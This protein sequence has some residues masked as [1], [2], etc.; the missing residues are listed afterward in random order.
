MISSVKDVIVK[1]ITEKV[2]GKEQLIFYYSEKGDSSLTGIENRLIKKQAYDLVNSNV[3]EIRKY[4]FRPAVSERG[5]LY[6]YLG[7]TL[8][9]PIHS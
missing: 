2:E 8:Y 4:Y 5:W 1:D 9:R 7:S 6:L 3:V